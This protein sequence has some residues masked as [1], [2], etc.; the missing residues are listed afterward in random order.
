MIFFFLFLIQ[1]HYNL[2]ISSSNKKSPSP[3]S[4]KVNDE[5]LVSNGKANSPKERHNSDAS[6]KK[7]VFKKNKSRLK[8]TKLV[9][10]SSIIVNMWLLN[11]I[12]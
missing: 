4:L 12:F 5:N 2:P 3:N 8:S 10:F 1:E 11:I 7:G 9:T 6:F